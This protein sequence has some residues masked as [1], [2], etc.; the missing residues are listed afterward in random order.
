[1]SKASPNSSDN[2]R[3][4]R[5]ELG[6][7]KN[8]DYIQ[9]IEESVRILY[10]ANASS[11]AHNLVDSDGNQATD[12][13]IAAPVSFQAAPSGQIVISDILENS[14]LSLSSTDILSLISDP[15]N[16]TLNTSS[17]CSTSISF[18]FFG[19]HVPVEKKQISIL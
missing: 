6:I 14:T 16:D 10:N 11:T 3:Y 4:G 18:S 8:D 7:L 15:N 12:F 9:N 2:S 1:M 13:N 19:F 5:F 17:I